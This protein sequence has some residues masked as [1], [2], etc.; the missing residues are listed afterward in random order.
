MRCFCLLV[1]LSGS[2][3]AQPQ[4]ESQVLGKIQEMVGEGERINFSN[5]YN[6]PD[7]NSQEQAFLGRLYEVFFAI[8][9]YLKAEY[10]S[11][12]EI[13][14]VEGTASSFGLS[15]PSVQLLLLSLIHI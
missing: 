9:G 8:P 13:P 12:G 5:L 2:L 3:L 14:T 10:Q 1:F 4:V 15:V 11:T 6:H 7:F